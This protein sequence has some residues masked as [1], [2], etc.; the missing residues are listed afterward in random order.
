MSKRSFRIAL[1]IV[2][3]SVL[4]AVGV[5]TYVVRAAF[6]YP[7]RSHAGQGRNIEVEIEAGMSFPAIAKR[8]HEAGVIDRPRWFRLYAMKRG[9]TT[10]VR[11]GRYVLSDRMTPKEVLDELLAGVS[12]VTV[13]VTI[14][15]GL[16]ILEIF[17]LIEAAGV[18]SAGELETLARDPAFL[19]QHGIEGETCEGYLFPDTYRFRVPTEPTAVL[20]RLIEQHRI[21]WERVRRRHDGRVQRIKARLG[22]TD[23]DLLI[24]ASIVEKEAVVDDERPRIAQVFLN[25]LTA[26]GFTPHRLDTDPTIR[27]GCTVPSDRSPACRAWDPTSRLHRAQLDD[28]ENRYN[29]YQH[30][31]L[32]PGPIASP[33]ERSLIAAVTP[34]GS[35]YY[36]FVSRN[37]GTHV[38][39]R[40]R[41]EHQR[42]VDQ[43]QR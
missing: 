22:W 17:A 11:T 31:G 20:G 34:D 15:E 26:P 16:H 32:P 9:A 23:R 41:R 14:P 13:A 35:D 24:L 7:E 4:L 37:D 2:A 40:T 19:G 29:T 1:A 30:D 43:Y 10:K 12:D 25:R 36:Y 33:G 5:V 8:L 28:A 21:V 18:A 38:F 6:D 39:S 42:A 3:T 27:Y